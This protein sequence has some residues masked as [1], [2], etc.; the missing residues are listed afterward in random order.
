MKHV[1]LAAVAILAA[2]SAMAEDRQTAGDPR[3]GAWGVDENASAAMLARDGWKFL[4]M[5]TMSWPDGRQ[6]VVTLWNSDLGDYARCF[7]YF[8][9]GM[10]QIGGKCERSG[11]GL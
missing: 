5:S 9:A 11:T 4:D 10:N 1:M 8:D 6:A 3:N 7:D 2:S